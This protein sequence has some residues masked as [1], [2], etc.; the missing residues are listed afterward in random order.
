[1]S[2]CTVDQVCSEFPRFV[3]NAAGSIQDLQIQQWLDQAAARINAALAQRGIG[4]FINGVFT[5]VNP[6]GQGQLD[7]LTSLNLDAG[8]GRLGTVFQAQVT[9]QPGE[10]SIAGQRLKQFETTLNDLRNGRYDNVFGMASRITGTAGAEADHTTPR[11]RGDN[12]PFGM[13]QKF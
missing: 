7:W 1:M 6:F 4:Q 5:P 13:N 8:I 11:E 12:T 9:M 3:R 2:Y 10:I